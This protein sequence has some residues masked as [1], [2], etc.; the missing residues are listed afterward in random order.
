MCR[1]RGSFDAR[2]LGAGGRNVKVCVIGAGV[3]GCATAYQ[4]TRDG[5]EVVLVDAAP[6]PATGAS[7]ANGAQ[8]SYRYVQPLAGPATLR[9]L[10]W[11]LLS[12][13]SPLGLRV[14]PSLS[15]W[16]WMLTFLAES[17]PAR[18]RHGSLSLLETALLS[19]TT[20]DRW[21]DEDGLD[22][23]LERNGK[24]VLCAD[25][26][27][28][29]QQGRQVALQVSAGAV[30]DLLDRDACIAREPALAAYCGFVGAVWTPGECVADPREFCRALVAAADRRGMKCVWSTPVEGWVIE[31]GRVLAARTGDT[32]IRADAYVLANGISAP[33]LAACLGESLP[34]EPIKGYSLSLRLRPNARAPRVSVTD[35][36][37]KTVFAPLNGQLRVAAMAELG[38]ND[39]SLP[40]RRLAQMRHTV[41]TVF[42]GLCDFDAP[43]SAWAGLRPATPSSLPIV[44]RSR[45]SNVFLNVGHGA[46]GFTLASGCAVR[47]AEAIHNARTARHASGLG[48]A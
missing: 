23:R 22:I 1:L 31:H 47:L 42:P 19:Q 18:V 21:L 44:R 11:M 5:H 40:Q 35:L 4:L 48:K 26:T 41:E 32:D 6:G 30:Q 7:F 24:L 12:R 25:R 13:R 28:F 45:V 20:L 2:K 43:E 3:V 33:K 17:T 36:A 37:Q 8:L 27:S 34:I 10:P 39:L 38:R 46:L 29:A 14:R 9:A 15:Q 16:R